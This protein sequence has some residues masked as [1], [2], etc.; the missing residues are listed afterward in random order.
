MFYHN[1]SYVL[2]QARLLIIPNVLPSFRIRMMSSNKFGILI[3]SIC[4]LT[5]VEL[6]QNY[7]SKSFSFC[8]SESV[9]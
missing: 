3:F 9:Y 2:I 6:N 7:E 8:I 1:L 5:C 4:R